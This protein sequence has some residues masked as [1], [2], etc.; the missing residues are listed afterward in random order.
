MKTVFC[1][2]MLSSLALC[3]SAYGAGCPKGQRKNEATL[4][5]MEKTW[6]RVVEQHDLAG[7]A[8]ILA[9][10]FEEAE[11]TGQLMNRAQMLSADSNR[12]VRYELSELHA[13]IYGDVGY[14]RGV[15]VAKRGGQPPMKTRFTDIFVYRDGRWQCVAGHESRFP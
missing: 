12:D 9:V 1:S 13:H 15:G 2:L 6:A 3:S 4:V 14:V 5:Q 8:C 10:E 7:L 11:S